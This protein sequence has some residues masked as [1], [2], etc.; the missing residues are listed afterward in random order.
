MSLSKQSKAKKIV[1]MYP[2]E[3]NINVN[4]ELYCF[5]CQTTVCCNKK[6]FVESHRKS[7]KHHTLISDTGAKQVKLSDYFII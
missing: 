5:L 7:K 6:F 2:N 4:K 3:F 1:N